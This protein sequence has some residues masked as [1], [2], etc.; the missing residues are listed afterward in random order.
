[1]ADTTETITVT[2]DSEVAEKYRSA[3]ESER[4]KLD[5][6]VNLRLREAMAKRKRLEDLEKSMRE[7]SR[8][9]QERGLTPE[10]LQSILDDE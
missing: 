4:L 9:A 2:V 5:W 7:M 10:I 6:L 8:K 1:M 3:S